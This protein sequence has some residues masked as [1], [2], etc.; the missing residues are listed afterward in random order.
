MATLFIFSATNMGN[1]VEYLAS[2]GFGS[3]GS[4]TNIQM[5]I[6]LIPFLIACLD[7]RRFRYFAMGS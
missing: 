1:V 7:W 5:Q 2:E 6:R 4:F 3:L